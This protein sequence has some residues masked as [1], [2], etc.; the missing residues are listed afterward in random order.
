MDSCVG[1]MRLPYCN[2]PTPVKTAAHCGIAGPCLVR[3]RAV[4]AV[5]KA[6]V[7]EGCLDERIDSGTFRH[8]T[9]KWNIKP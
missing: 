7:G 2:V 3:S 4:V 6:T 1:W 8:F 5:H 9:W